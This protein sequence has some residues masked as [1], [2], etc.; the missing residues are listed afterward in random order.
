MGIYLKKFETHTQYDTYINGSSAILP[1]VSICTTEGDVHYSPFVDPCA[2]EKV[3]T[4]YEMVDLALPS[5]VKWANKNIGAL[6]VTD[7]GQKFQWGDVQGF[8]HDQVSGGCKA[9]SW[10]NY[11]YSNGT[12]S[13]STSYMTK[14]NSTDHLVTLEAM[15][16]AAVAN[17]GGN[18]RMATETEFNELLNTDNC[19]KQWVTNYGD[20]SING[21]LFTSVRNSNTLF[22]PAAGYCLD[23]NVYK[24]NSYGMYWSSSLYTS[25]VT[26]GRLLYFYDGYILMGSYN[27]CYGYSV[28]GV[29]GQ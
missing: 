26:S 21:Y 14:Y 5:G 10:A 12:S 16:D 4:T 23:G 3:K 15:D 29:V 28:R 25:N 27:R 2:S 18:W 7:Y 1:N 20:T 8:T 17:M 6:T 13:P 19:T 24:V 22:F 9:Y 11:K